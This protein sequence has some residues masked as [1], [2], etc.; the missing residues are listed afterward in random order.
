MQTVLLFLLD[1]HQ[2]GKVKRY[3]SKNLKYPLLGKSF[4]LVTLCF[5]RSDQHNEACSAISQLFTNATK[6]QSLP[7]REHNLCPS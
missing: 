1:F 5:M 7:H 2:R 6:T 3:F 4:G